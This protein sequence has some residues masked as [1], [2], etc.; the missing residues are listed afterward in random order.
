MRN[1]RRIDRQAASWVGACKIARDP[2]LGWRECRVVDISP[3]GLAITVDYPETTDLA[4][5]PISVNLSG[6]DG[7]VNVRLDGEIKNCA[8]T[9]RQHVRVG[10]EFVRASDTEQ[11]VSTVLR[12][13]SEA[14]V[15]T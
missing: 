7:A 14:L 2:Y 5:R 6:D 10:I 3:L 11:A 9:I 1:R 12:A 4:G 13:M 15:A 8:L